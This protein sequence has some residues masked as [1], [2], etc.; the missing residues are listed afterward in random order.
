MS[1]IDDVLNKMKPVFRA[2]E[3]IAALGG[4][5]AYAY[6]A[7]HR[8][9]RAKKIGSVRN[10]WWAKKGATLEEIACAVSYPCYLSFHSALHAHG[11]TTQ[12]PRCVQLAVCRK[13]RKYSFAGG[14]AREYRMKKEEFREFEIKEG[15]PIANAEKAFA[16]CLRLPRACPNAILAEAMNE[17]NIWKVK[18]MC[19]K[20]MLKRLK[21]VDG[22]A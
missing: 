20:R 6:V 22:N 3:F 7:L 18:K 14:E 9:K 21:E 17:M 5:A 16:D 19:N 1:T 11:L 12:I 4:K 2:R 10:G 8:L 15:I 13:A